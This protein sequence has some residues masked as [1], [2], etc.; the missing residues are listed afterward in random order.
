MI[1]ALVYYANGQLWLLAVVPVLIFAWTWLL[2]GELRKKATR[3]VLEHDRFT[4]S[5]YYGLG[6][7]KQYGLNEL[8]G[9][10]SSVLSSENG[11]FEYLYLMMD[12]KRI[13]CISSFHHLNFEEIRD[14]LQQKVKSLEQIPFDFKEE[15]RDLFS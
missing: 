9:L 11:N 14:H 4:V 13:A 8:S 10:R 3:L 2:L 6:K 7:P 12:Q 1:I 15:L 5:G